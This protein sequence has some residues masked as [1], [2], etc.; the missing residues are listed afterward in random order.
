MPPLT[1]PKA[2]ED[3]AVAWVIQL[4]RQAGR[5]PRD[6]RY[7]GAP[8]DIESGD[9][10]IEVKAFG[11]HARGEFL[12]LETRQVQEAHAQPDRFFLYVVE[13]VAQGDPVRFTLKIFGGEQLRR[14]LAWA[15]ERH[16]FE[17]PLPVR[18]YDSAPEEP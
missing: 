7:R 12:W 4:E 17:V 8:A 6:T 2:K 11:K 14:L 15:K 9:R 18:E 10:I 1:S 5:E 13:N 16:Y 3:A